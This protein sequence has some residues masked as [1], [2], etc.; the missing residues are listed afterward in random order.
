MIEMVY[1]GKESGEQGE[2]RIP[3]NIRQMGGGGKDQK[4][5]IEDSVM[6]QIKKTPKKEESIKYGVLLGNISRSKGVS[7]IFVKASVEV[8]DIIENTVIFNDDIWATIYKD[9]NKYFKNLDIVGWF[10]SEPYR[11]TGDLNGIKKVHLDNFAGNDKVC[12][13]S[14]RTEKE[15]SFYIYKKGKL[16]KQNGYYIYCE[17]NEKMKK[18]IKDLNN[19]DREEKNQ[20]KNETVPAKHKETIKTSEKI[21]EKTGK[22]KKS[23]KGLRDVI[24]EEGQRSRQGRVAYGISG[25]LI[26]ALLLSTV[27]MLN[28]YGELKNIKQTLSQYSMDKEARVVNQLLAGE[29]ETTLNNPQTGKST[30]TEKNTETAANKVEGMEQITNPT[31]SATGTTNAKTNQ[32]SSQ[33]K[34]SHAQNKS[35]KAVKSSASG[36]YYKVKAGQTL[37]DI[38]MKVYG[39]SKMVDEIKEYNDIDDDYTIIEG[40][41]ILLP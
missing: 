40:Q 31:P 16:E 41:K 21:I 35:D 8:V 33:Q 24:R 10:V 12:F 15:D 20:I 9:I 11:T 4:I 1:D 13:L 30:E 25:L 2:V 5:Y 18:Y 36:K 39:T 19:S 26:V 23:P 6:V 37:Y 38:S 27:V 17:K 22:E 28:N 32:N 14:D 7:Y 29:M 3:K 34:Q